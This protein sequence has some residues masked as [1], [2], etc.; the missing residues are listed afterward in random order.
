MPRTGG[1]PEVEFIPR[2]FEEHTDIPDADYWIVAR[3]QKITPIKDKG[4]S[5]TCVDKTGYEL[6]ITLWS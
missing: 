2:A 6:E 4:R 5:L 3:V 1:H